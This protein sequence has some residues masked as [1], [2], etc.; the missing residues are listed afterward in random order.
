MVKYYIVIT[1]RTSTRPTSDFTRPGA[2]SEKIGDGNVWVDLQESV[3][4]VV[5][6]HT[7]NTHLG[8]TVVRLGTEGTKLLLQTRED[9]TILCSESELRLREGS[10]EQIQATSHFSRER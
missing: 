4:V 6:N 5:T 10:H 7:Y 8:L 2:W 3:R 1:G 9:K